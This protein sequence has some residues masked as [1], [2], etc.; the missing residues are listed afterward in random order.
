MIYFDNSATTKP[1]SE[2]LDTFVK[3]NQNY[4]ANPSSLHYLGGQVENLIE[5]A[6]KQLSEILCT[7]PNELFFTSGGTESNNIAIKGVVNQYLHRGNHLITTQI[8]HPSVLETFKSLQEQGFEVTYLPVDSTGRVC[9][10]ELKNALTDRTIL[11]SIMHVNNEVG[12]IQP[13]EEIGLILKRYPKIYF[14]VDHVQGFG[15]IPIDFHKFNID[16]ATM[17]GHK[18]NGLKGTGLLF[19][20]DGLVLSPLIKGGSQEKLVRSG[21]ENTGGIVSLAKAVRITF[22]KKAETINEM[23]QIMDYLREE[24]LKEPEVIFHTNAVN[25]APHILNVSVKGYKG[26]VLVHALA[27]EGVCVSTTSA[28]S[29]KQTTVSHTLIAMGVSEEIANSS[30]RIS[31]G[32]FNTLGE[33]EH[34]VRALKAI[35][36]QLV[37]VGKRKS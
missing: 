32:A 14:H 6:R 24:L 26:E 1:F 29:S 33:A 3:V 8:E 37:E 10:I 30:I 9:P 28:C 2:V 20:R 15:K 19:K 18:I 7:K 16:L 34:F 23:N 36:N 11:V 25:S 5:A 13:L 35:K 21:T 31:L 22:E 12:I 27:K 4:Y 17:S